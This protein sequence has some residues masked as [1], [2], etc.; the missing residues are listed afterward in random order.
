[1]IIV[2]PLKSERLFLAFPILMRVK[3]SL[4]GKLPEMVPLRRQLFKGV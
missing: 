4:G 2:K 1:M 3:D